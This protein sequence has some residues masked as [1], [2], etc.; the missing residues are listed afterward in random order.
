M[1]AEEVEPREDRGEGRA[2]VEPREDR[3]EGREVSAQIDCLFDDLVSGLR[4]QKRQKKESL[5]FRSAALGEE[6][7]RDEDEET[8]EVPLGMRL[9]TD[10]W[11]G[12]ANMRTLKTLLKRVDENGW[13]RSA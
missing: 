12:D 3:G 13:E 5:Q 8:G 2:E 9:P 10:Q 4:A 7:R 11:D 6:E 1:Q